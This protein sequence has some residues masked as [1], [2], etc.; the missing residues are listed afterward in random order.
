LVNNKVAENVLLNGTLG[1]ITVDTIWMDTTSL[2]TSVQFNGKITLSLIR[3][4]K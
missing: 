2:K 1:N 4:V 3:A